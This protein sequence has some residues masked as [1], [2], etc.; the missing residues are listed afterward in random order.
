M[1]G[2][3]GQRMDISE[4]VWLCVLLHSSKSEADAVQI[5]FFGI[6]DLLSILPYYLELMLHQDTVRP[7]TFYTLPSRERLAVNFVQVHDLA[8]IPPVARVQA[9]PIQQHHPDVRTQLFMLQYTL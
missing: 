1:F 6:M 2:T 5:A 7:R 9:V 8:Y 3:F 4:V